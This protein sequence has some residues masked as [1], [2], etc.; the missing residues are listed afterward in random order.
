MTSMMTVSG[1]EMNSP[2][3]SVCA[4]FAVFCAW[5]RADGHHGDD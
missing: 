5:D 2:P 3:D 1:G 4:L